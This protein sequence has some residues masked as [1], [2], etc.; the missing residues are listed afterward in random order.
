MESRLIHDDEKQSKKSE[1][2]CT[3]LSSEL[4]KGRQIPVHID[5]QEDRNSE[6]VHVSDNRRHYSFSPPL[7]SMP[8]P[9]IQFQ[10]TLPLTFRMNDAA[11]NGY[12]YR[13]T[14]VKLDPCKHPQKLDNANTYNVT[15]TCKNSKCLKLYCK[16]F[17]NQSKCHNQCRCLNCMNDDKPEHQNAFDKA[18]TI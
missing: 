18:G 3:V 1:G 11:A 7:F 4:K 6:K 13:P 17:A 5:G 9:A 14:E 10:A 15:C 2:V 16:C 8:S 12:S